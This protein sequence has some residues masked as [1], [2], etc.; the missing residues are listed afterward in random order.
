MMRY[1]RLTFL[2]V[3]VPI[4]VQAQSTSISLDEA[5]ELF[6]QH[7]LQQELAR[8]DRLRKQGKAIQYRSYPNPEISINREQL[9]AGS[10]DYR[11]T[12]YLVSQPIELLGQPF[13]RSKSASKSQKAAKLQYEYDRRQLLGEVKTLYA[14]SWQLSQKL[15]IYNR[16]L[17]VIRKARES[18]RERQ[19]EGTYSGLQLQR[20]NIELN[21][22]RKQRDRIRL[23]LKQV[24]HQLSSYFYKGQDPA[25]NIQ[26][27][28]SLTVSPLHLQKKT[29]IQYA[30]A[31]RTDLQAL[32]QSVDASRLQYKVE[33]RNRLPDL[34]LNLGYK[35]QSDGAEGWVLGGSIGI[36]LFNQNQGNV[37][38]IRA[39]TRTQQTRLTL[40][41]QKVRNQVEVAYERVELISEQW[42]AMEKDSMGT[43]MLKAARAAYQQGRYSLVKL[44]DATRAYVDGQTMIY[45]TIADYNQALFKLDVLTAGRIS[46]TQHN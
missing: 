2:L 31:N 11:E 39:Q 24:Q 10:I 8:Y 33:K 27:S 5:V 35:D 18:A 19:A 28:D 14:E 37:K 29:L 46:N 44:L 26:T 34:N 25:P 15:R 41:Q 23:N 45:E 32:K 13:L 38:I 7:N 4:L 36:P 12:T 20:F 30:L 16:A 21:R 22:Y 3:L 42:E 40:K 6:K 17:E 9:T 1:L 43:S